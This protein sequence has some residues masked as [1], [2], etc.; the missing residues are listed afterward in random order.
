MEEKSYTVGKGWHSLVD[1]ATQRLEQLGVKVNSHY[2]KY[3]TLRFD[4]APEPR[5]ATIILNEMEDRSK[6]ICE[7]CGSTDPD[8]DIV[9][10]RSGWIK[11]LCPA[12][13]KKAHLMQT[14]Y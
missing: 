11:A 12:C 3:G 8:V 5:E 2:E 1:E 9:E 6:H 4:V 7:N 13:C 10:L 14:D